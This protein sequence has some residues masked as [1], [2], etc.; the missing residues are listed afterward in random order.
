MKLHNRCLVFCVASLLGVGCNKPTNRDQ[1]GILADPSQNNLGKRQIKIIEQVSAKPSNLNDLAKLVIATGD[2]SKSS[3]ELKSLLQKRAQDDNSETMVIAA[4][5]IAESNSSENQELLLMAILSAFP[6]SDSRI[7]LAKNLPA[8]RTRSGLISG[9]CDKLSEEDDMRRFEDLYNTIP[10]GQDRQTVAAK[11][12][13]KTF[14]KE[15][16]TSGLTFIGG[17]EMPEERYTALMITLKQWQGIKDDAS[18][19]QLI[20]I[21]KGLPSDSSARISRIIN[22]LK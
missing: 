18:K 9:L 3:E 20:D 21:S 16:V 22:S 12:A 6:D 17:L 14:E 19:R 5:L 1:T 15:G 10:I 8:G 7:V 13:A 11:F 4:Q 2:Y